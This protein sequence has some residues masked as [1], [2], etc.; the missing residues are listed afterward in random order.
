M[1]VL[2]TVLEDL[3]RIV[4]NVSIFQIKIEKVPVHLTAPFSQDPENRVTLNGADLFGAN[5]DGMGGG[6]T[7]LFLPVIRV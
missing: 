1:T 4:E 3:S 5:C 7:V 6:C 2:D